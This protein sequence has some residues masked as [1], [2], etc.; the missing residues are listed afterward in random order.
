[1]IFENPQ[2][3]QIKV[4]HLKELIPFLLNNTEE[5]N[6]VCNLQN[7]SFNPE[8]PAHISQNFKDVI[9][10]V[11]AGYTKESAFIDKE[12]FCF[13]AGFG[14]E[15]FGSFIKVPLENIIQILINDTP[16]FINIGAT[17]PKPKKTENPFL[18]N[19]R[20]KKFLRPN[21]R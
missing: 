21:K 10:F 6:V 18:L 19:P 14:E 12:Y 16:A 17:L 15:N 7:I 1:M 2:F 4:N 8:L 13:E 11:I 5:F 20:N 9:M 3:N